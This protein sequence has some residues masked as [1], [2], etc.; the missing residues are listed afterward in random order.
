MQTRRILHTML[1]VGDMSRSV[2]FYTDVLGMQVLRTLEQPDEKYSLAFLGYG[3]EASTAVLELT[4]NHGVSSYD[5]GTG[6]GHVAIG[7]TDC[8]QACADIRARGSDIVLE[9][10]PLK[11]TKEVI[12]F[13]LDPDGY[14]IELI[15][16]PWE[17][18]HD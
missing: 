6:Y 3:D 12:A 9:P 17:Q 14:R 15:Q 10:V 7:V 8:H 5:P 4:Y 1:R 16:K 13:V 11:G 18:G 2:K